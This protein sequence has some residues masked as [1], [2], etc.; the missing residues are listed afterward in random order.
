M[1]AMYFAAFCVLIRRNFMFKIIGDTIFLPRGDSF[2]AQ[3]GIRRADESDYIPDEGDVIRFA[4]KKKYSDAT[5][6]ILKTIPYDSLILHL[7]PEDTKALEFGR[8]VYD[9][10]V[11][12]TNGDVTTIIPEDPEKEAIFNIGKE[13]Y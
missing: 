7:E 12:D 11:T 1:A 5:P 10:E 3:I 4:V 2:Y 13:V 6:L 9:I 8:Y